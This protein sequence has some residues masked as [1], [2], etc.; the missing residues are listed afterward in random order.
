MAQHIVLVCAMKIN[1]STCA[2]QLRL[3]MV[4][5]ALRT[6]RSSIAAAA[7]HTYACRRARIG[8]VYTCTTAVRASWHIVHG[9][10]GLHADATFV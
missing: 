2:P 9:C 3:I 5:P 10:I 8:P 1:P 4:V 7:R 6:I